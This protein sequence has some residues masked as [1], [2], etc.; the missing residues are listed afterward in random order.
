MSPLQWCARILVGGLLALVPVACSD[1]GGDAQMLVRGPGYDFKASAIGAYADNQEAVVLAVSRISGLDASNGT[2]GW[3]GSE[4]K[5]FV[6]GGI[7]YADRQCEAYMNALFWFHRAKS[8]TTSQID[9][10]GAATAGL[11]GIVQA[12]ARA[13]SITAVAFGLTSASVENIGSGLLYELDPSAVRDLVRKLQRRYE[14]GIPPMGYNDRAGAFRAIQGYVSICLPASI[15]TEVANAV[16]ASKA[17]GVDGDPNKGTPP[18]AKIGP[19]TVNTFGENDETALLTAYWRPAGGAINKENEAK[20]LA[21]MKTVGA[22]GVRIPTFLSAAAHRAQRVKVAA[23]LG[24]K[25][26]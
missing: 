25:K 8:R 5:T 16:K 11:L 13:I 12:T 24:L 18:V 3:T 2:A 1:A 7:Q 20:L 23:A 14:E 22:G 26:T 9:M 15:E 4:W 17:E 21:E 19:I 6:T 10:I